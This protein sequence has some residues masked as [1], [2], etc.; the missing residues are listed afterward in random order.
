MSD[1]NPAGGDAFYRSQYSR[2][3]GRL[4][5]EVRK[6]AFGEDLGQESWRSTTE[7]A[8]IAEL[9]RLGPGAYVLDVACGAGGPSFAFVERTG[10]RL[11]GVDIVPEGVSCATEEAEK[12]GLADRA[13]FV[14]I[15][16]GQPLPFGDGAFDAVMCIDSIS[17]FPDRHSALRDWAR[18]LKSRGRLIFTDPFVVTGPILKPEID[19]RCSLGSN[20]FFVPPAFNETAASEAGFQI[21]HSVDRAAAA[22]EISGRWRDARAKRAQALIDEEG[23]DWFQRRQVMLDTTS[24][25]AAEGRLTRF[26][27]LAEKP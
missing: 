15:A 18:L 20:L 3:Y 23:E 5:S 8:E 13:N 26:F 4:A 6:E 17:H 7:Q 16:A 14:V 21:V 19:G 1:L 9:L 2:L 12:R 10:C 22:A 24:R 27:Y 11:V 25:L